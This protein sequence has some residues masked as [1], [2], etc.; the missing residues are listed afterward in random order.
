MMRRSSLFAL[1]GLVSGLLLVSGCAATM[2]EQPKYE[3]LAYS[4][5]YPDG[6]SA[7][8]APANTV[9]RGVAANADP[10][11]ATG[12]VNGT[13]VPDFPFPLTVDDLKRGEGLFNDTCAPCHGRTGAGDGIVVQRGFTKPPSLT[14]P[15]IVAL[16]PGQVFGVITN[17]FGAMPPYGQIL[18]PTDRWR[19]TGYVRALQA[20]QSGTLN[21]VPPEM[22]NQIKP[23]GGQ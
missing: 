23:A 22:Q 16:S 4:E 18:Q 2:K 10:A 20:S 7:R 14:A 5:F 6:A 3:P 21:D 1:V 9:A 8:Y 12:A 17:G 11:L 13:P 19:V 15:N